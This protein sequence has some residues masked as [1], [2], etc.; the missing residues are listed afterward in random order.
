MMTDSS[1]FFKQD[2]TFEKN[3]LCTKSIEILGRIA[4]V[5]TNAFV[6]IEF[7]KLIVRKKKFANFGT[8]QGEGELDRELCEMKW[9]IFSFPY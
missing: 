5:V 1:R 7:L 4:D 3:I 2:L 8:G 6:K 9:K